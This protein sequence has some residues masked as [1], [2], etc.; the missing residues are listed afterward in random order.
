MSVLNELVE[1]GV[2]LVLDDF[3]TGYS[4]LSYL[5]QFPLTGSRSTADSPKAFRLLSR[6]HGDRKGREYGHVPGPRHD[7]GGR[8]RGNGGT[9]RNN[10]GASPAPAPRVTFSP[11]ATP[12]RRSPSSS[13][14]VCRPIRRAAP[15]PCPPSFY[16]I[17]RRSAPVA[18]PGGVSRDRVDHLWPQGTGQI[19]SHAGRMTSWAPGIAAAVA[20]PPETLTS[21]SARRGSPWWE[22][23][24]APASACGQ[25]PRPRR[26]SGGDCRRMDSAIEAASARARLCSS[27]KSNPREPIVR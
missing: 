18:F 14:G 24:P 23:A 3:G 13:M 8:R 11:G 12:P 25:A 7:G 21:R 16:G 26:P 9:A 5:K 17:L 1:D 2:G 10:C 4:S 27:S 15:R 20:R 19:V 22:R 6:G